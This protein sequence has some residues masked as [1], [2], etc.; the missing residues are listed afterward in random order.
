MKQLKSL[1]WGLGALVALPLLASCSDSLSD[2]GE[3]VQPGQDK[4]TGQITYVQFAA[5]TVA[6]PEVN[7]TSQEALLQTL[8]RQP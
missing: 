7:S 8:I 4:V 1:R 2:I 3:S 6:S 5:S